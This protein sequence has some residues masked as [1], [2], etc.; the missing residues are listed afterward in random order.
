MPR[1]DFIQPGVSGCSVYTCRQGDK[2]PAVH[3]PALQLRQLNGSEDGVPQAP[4]PERTNFGRSRHSS[5]RQV[6]VPPEL[7]R[8][9]LPRRGR[10]SVRH[11]LPHVG[12]RVAGTG[13]ASA[14]AVPYRLASIGN[15]GARRPGEQHRRPAG[16]RTAAAAPRPFPGAGRWGAPPA[17]VGR[18]VRGLRPHPSGGDGS[19]KGHLGREFRLWV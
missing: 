14:P 11:Q 2:R 17:P 3:R 10:P 9:A 12:Q 6:P 5:L 15:A 7:L 1:F 13:T 18:A 8:R 4:R 19:W 16:A